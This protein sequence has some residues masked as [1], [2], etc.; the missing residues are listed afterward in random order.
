MAPPAAHANPRAPPHAP[1]DVSSRLLAP[2]AAASAEVFC[3][4]G[5]RLLPA[6]GRA[7]Y[8]FSLRDV[9]RMLQVGA[10]ARLLRL[11][12]AVRPQ[13]GEGREGGEVRRAIQPPIT[14]VRVD[15][16]V[17]V[18]SG[19]RR[20]GSRAPVR[21]PQRAAPRDTHRPAQPRVPCV[22]TQ[23]VTSI[24]PPQCGANVRGTLQRLWLHEHLRVY[25]DRLAC[26]PDAAWLRGELARVARA[27]FGWQEDADQLFGPDE[28]VVF[29]E[30]GWRRVGSL[31]AGGRGSAW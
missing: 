9:G 14:R 27:R 25:G 10:H 4:A 8:A 1:S 11:C 6:P 17:A 26:A 7:H 31:W 30:A 23:G 12:A 13:R 15:H 19:W 2:L 20:A 5:E 29:G 21:H 16:G 3:A 28:E 24:R 22:P 18:V